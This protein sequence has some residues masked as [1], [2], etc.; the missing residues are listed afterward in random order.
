MKPNRGLPWHRTA[1]F[2]ASWRPVNQKVYLPIPAKYSRGRALL[3]LLHLAKRE[4]KPRENE[5]IIIKASK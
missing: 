5:I 1:A 3:M 4:R 2:I